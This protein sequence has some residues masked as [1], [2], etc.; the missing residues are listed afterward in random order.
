MIYFTLTGIFYCWAWNPT[1]SVNIRIVSQMDSFPW[2]YEHT[3][4]YIYVA[5]DENC[6]EHLS[7]SSYAFDGTTALL[8]SWNC[9][10]RTDITL[11]LM[12][13][14]WERERLL[15]KKKRSLWRVLWKTSGYGR[16]IYGLMLYASY[17]ALS[18]GP[19]LILNVLTQYL[20][21]TRDLNQGEVAILV[22]LLF[23]VPMLASIFAAQSNVIMAHIG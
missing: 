18:F 16:L 6:Q 15:P 21:G 17:T 1:F 5:S 14:H 7:S 11:T 12:Y 4:T 13:R 2:I 22:I 3:H 19:V 10:Y 9:S 23:L 20:Q 8:K